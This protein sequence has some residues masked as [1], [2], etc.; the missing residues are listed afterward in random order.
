MSNHG[1]ECTNDTEENQNINN[2]L[3][4]LGA[5]NNPLRWQIDL[6]VRLSAYVGARISQAV[7]Q[8]VTGL[9]P[10]GSQFEFW[11]QKQYSLL[12]II[13]TT[14]GI[15]TASYTMGTKGSFLGGEAAKM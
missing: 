4:K 7:Q 13:Q 10:E 8:L 11:Q 1:C 6:C 5:K 2:F 12:H 15:H 9:M 14:S 3:R